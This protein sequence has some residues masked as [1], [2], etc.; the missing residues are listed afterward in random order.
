MAVT[1][2]MKRDNANEARNGMA[3]IFAKGESG[4]TG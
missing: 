4:T 2:L 3:M 1:L